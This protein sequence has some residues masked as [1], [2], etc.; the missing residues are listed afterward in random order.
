MNKFFG[1][2]RR[3]YIPLL[4]PQIKRLLVVI[5]SL[6]FW[7]LP[8]SYWLEV[9]QYNKRGLCNDIE[10]RKCL[11]GLWRRVCVLTALNLSEC[12]CF[13]VVAVEFYVLHNVRSYRCFFFL[14]FICF[15]QQCMLLPTFFCIPPFICSVLFEPFSLFFC[16]HCCCWYYYRLHRI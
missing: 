14:D 12:W 1:T 15:A 13:V 3:L 7:K 10:D 16:Q 4:M 11:L 8:T 5:Q 2:L 9:S 6:N